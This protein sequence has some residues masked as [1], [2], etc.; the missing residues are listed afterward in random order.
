MKVSII[1]PACN[2]DK[3]FFQCAESISNQNYNDFEAIVVNDGSTDG[4][5]GILKSIEKRDSRFKIFCFEKRKGIVHALNY[6]LSVSSGDY[7]ARMDADD[8][9]HMDR[10]LMQAEFLDKNPKVDVVSCLVQKFSSSGRVGN[11]FKIYEEWINSLVHHNDI[12]R[13]IFVE[14]PLV[15]PSIMM[16]RSVIQEA[17]G[18]KDNGWAED[19]DLWL[20][21]YLAGKRFEKINKILLYWRDDP[22][23]LSRESQIY[24]QMNFYKCKTHYLLNSFL[25]STK[26]VVVWGAKRTSRK[27]SDLL[28]QSGM[29]I[30]Y[31]IDVDIKKI[32][33]RINGIKV[34]SPDDR[35]LFSDVPV[36]S[37]V[38]TLGAR[39]KI[40][41]RLI[42]IGR[43]ESSDFFMMA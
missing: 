42:S 19:Y 21:L 33:N 22:G 8:I 32:G 14:S 23:R 7:I 13:D 1:I 35:H 25:K 24:S 27:Y 28:L 43:K 6:A 3:F 15:H 11:G 40:R 36:L 30:L 2:V 41:A 39:D 31:Y 37:Y 5:S 34:I 18:Y 10:I 16:R 4:T 38:S 9:M 26:N 17:G 29:D 20:R 12:V